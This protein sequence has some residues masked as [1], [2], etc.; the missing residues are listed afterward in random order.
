MN[1]NNVLERD[2][3]KG[4][5]GDTFEGLSVDAHK[6]HQKRDCTAMAKVAGHNIRLKVDTRA[7]ADPLPLSVLKKLHNSTQPLQSS[8]IL[9]SW[10]GGEL[11]NVGTV[12]MPTEPRSR[13]ANFD[14]FLVKKRKQALRGFQGCESLRLGLLREK[15]TSQAQ[16]RVFPEFLDIL[17]G[18]SHGLQGN[19]ISWSS[20][21]VRLHFVVLCA[22]LI[23]LAC[24]AKLQ[25]KQIMYIKYIFNLL[26]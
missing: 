10:G 26:D 11:R 9:R 2:V 25:V 18:I 8:T 22:P 7:R 6:V 17:R 13:L 14:F 1:V 5:E 19:S 15:K 23:I 4:D 16:Q 21:G 20:G 3:N 12:C 24:N